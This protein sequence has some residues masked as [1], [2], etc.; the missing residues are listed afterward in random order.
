MS[1]PSPAYAWAKLD[2]DGAALP[3]VEHAADVAAVLTQLAVE[4]PWRRRL[5]SAAGRPLS[6]QDCDRLAVLA[7]LH[8]LGKANRGFWERQFPVKPVVGHTN[9]TAALFYVDRICN[10]P[11]PS[12]LFQ[13][14]QAWGAADLFSAAMAHHGRPLEAYA[15]DELRPD[16]GRAARD[17]LQTNKHP[18]DYWLPANGYDP[19]EQLALLLQAARARF[20]VAFCDGPALPDTAPFISLFYGLLTLADW[21]GSDTFLFPVAGPHG[22]DR[23]P[24][25][26]DAAVRAVAGRGLADLPTPFCTFAAAFDVPAPRGLQAEAVDASLGRRSTPPTAGLEE[27]MRWAPPGRSHTWPA[28]GTA[29]PGCRVPPGRGARRR[30]GS[31]PRAGCTPA[32]RPCPCRRSGSWRSGGRRGRGGTP[33]RAAPGLPGGPRRCR[34]RN[35][36]PGAPDTPRPARVAEPGFA[37]PVPARARGTALEPNCCGP[38]RQDLVKPVSLYPG[39][40]RRILFRGLAGGEQQPRA[41]Q[42]PGRHHQPVGPALQGDVPLHPLHRCHKLLDQL[43][44]GDLA[45][46][47]ALALGQ[48][49]TRSIG[50]SKPVRCSSGLP[51]TRGGVSHP[52]RGAPRAAHHL[53]R[54]GPAH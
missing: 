48:L 11:V 9:E 36:A 40:P 51:G 49:S 3:L 6:A 37:R 20:P 30:C 5:E 43:Q 19:L 8:D 27:L 21:L 23:E 44:D 15:G 13:L 1:S 39:I 17:L 25:R 47:D 14:I 35:A 29:P 52:G 41:Q 26:R 32:R 31:A 50:P 2:A 34:G 4:T 38:H 7:Y 24:L 22:P 42:Q 12:Q 33:C 46:V 18:A 53:H 28:A 10:R 45:Q 54:P 16:L